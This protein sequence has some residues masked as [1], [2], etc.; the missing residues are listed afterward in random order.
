M[1]TRFL[2]PGLLLIAALA[3]C[4]NPLD[5]TP[6]GSV[7]DATAISDAP[8]AR[9]AVAGMYAGLQS[10]SLYG[11]ELVELGDLSADNA[12]NSGTYT[13]YFEADD[14]ALKAT[15]AAVTDV[16]MQSY[17][18]INRANEIL[19]RVPEVQDLDPDEAQAMLGQ[20]YFIRALMYHNL[21][22]LFA[23][24][25]AA[26]AGVPL[27]LQPA[28]SLDEAK[29]IA[30]ATVGDV[31]AQI[32]SDLDAAEQNITDDGS[33]TTASVGA[34][35]ALRARVLLYR[36]D[37][38]GAAT[39][40]KAVED[41]GYSLVTYADLFD[42][43]GS[44]TDEDIF[45]IPFT[46]TQESFLSYDYFT[47]GLGG[48]YE[49]R[50]TRDLMHAYDPNFDPEN[51]PISAYAPTDER[52]QWNIDIAGSRVYGTKYKSIIGLEYFPVLR[53]GEIKLIRA[54]ALARQNQLPDARQ[55]VNDIRDRAGITQLGVLSQADL[56]DSIVV[57]RRK[58]LALEGD[59]WPDLV[60]LGRAASVMG[61]AE[62]QTLY[63]IPQREL[64][65]SPGLTQNPGY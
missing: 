52:G 35:H 49:L 45:K 64:D 56:I 60:R 36:G 18:V 15:N 62:S 46:Q 6:H 27:R 28:Q 39:E 3:A 19:T 63:P 9:A 38:A 31:Y 53:L 11:E 43:N 58:E 12:E 8:S 40:A 20:A 25:A 22:K 14:N 2:A 41:L 34:V 26:D 1:R 59:R 65:V 55:E 57:E 5:V 61:I 50:P 24:R 48:V 4:S 17:D 7:P 13:S 32:L 44:V 16:W 33:V 21:V 51:D 29:D 37:Y 30:R 47:R 42:P 54:E 10:L 23:G